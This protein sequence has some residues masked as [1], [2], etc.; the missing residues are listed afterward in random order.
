ME[1]L[2]DHFDTMK[3]FM[4]L[5]QKGQMDKSLVES[6]CPRSL[7]EFLTYLTK[8]LKDNNIVT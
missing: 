5:V 4:N 1:T 6:L 8:I 2:S 7:T 3:S